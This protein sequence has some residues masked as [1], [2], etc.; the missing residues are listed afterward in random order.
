MPEVL[1]AFDGVLSDARLGA[2]GARVR[3]IAAGIRAPIFNFLHN[4]GISNLFVTRP[5]VPVRL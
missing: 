2:E 4:F 3:T 5:N 1:G